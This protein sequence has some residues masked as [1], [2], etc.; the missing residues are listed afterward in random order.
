[1]GNEQQIE[2]WN[3]PPGERWAALQDYTDQF[4][5][6]IMQ[7][8][9]P[10]V[11]AKPGETVL[12][13][14]CGCGTTTFTFALNVRPEGSVAGIDVSAPML[15][16]ARARAAASN[17]DIVFIEADAS[18]Y[19][20]QPVFDLVVSRFGVMFFDD[21]VTAFG[22]IRKA[23]APKG[24][25]AFVCWRA[26]AE[27]GW[28]ATPVAAALPFLPPQETPDPYAPGPF[29]FADGERLK[30]ILENAGFR[31]IRVDAFDGYMDMAKTP[32][33]AAMRTLQVG[34]LSRATAELDEG[35]RAKIRDVVAVAMKQYATPDGVRAPVAC[36]FVGVT[37]S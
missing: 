13:I 27:N 21:P 14:G 30:G 35:A 10:F 25:L 33:E 2:Y 32:E 17:A 20:F 36:W 22:N 16:V 1:M 19:D 15:A 23:L 5:G 26:L 8:F 24:R 3:G 9:I 12:D 11:N 31:D 37:K 18:T 34:P 4:L 6:R 7:A 28:A 29:A